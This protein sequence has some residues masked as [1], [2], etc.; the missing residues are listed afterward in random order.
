[1]PC[2]TRLFP[3]WPLDSSSTCSISEK[4]FSEIQLEIFNRPVSQA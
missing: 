3:G 4:A 1:M 2:Q